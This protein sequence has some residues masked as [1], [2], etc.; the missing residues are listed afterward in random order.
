MII[1][2]QNRKRVERVPD[3]M[4]IT[5][6]G[7]IYSIVSSAK[8]NPCMG[9]YENEERAIEVLREMFQYIRSGKKTYIMPAK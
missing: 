2:L 1:Y 9:N 8:M 5:R 3:R 4:W 7:D 6:N